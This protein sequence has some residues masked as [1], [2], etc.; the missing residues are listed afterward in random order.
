MAG[1]VMGDTIVDNKPAYALWCISL[2]RRAATGWVSFGEP[3]IRASHN[4]S[5]PETPA[6]TIHCNEA[7]LMELDISLS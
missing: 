4:T 3:A 2:T 7:T 5:T 6:S 1:I